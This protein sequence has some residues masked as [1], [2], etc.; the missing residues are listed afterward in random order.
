MTAVTLLISGANR[1]IGLALA[2]Q[3]AARG[4]R[5]VATAR[6]P[7]AAQRLQA[8]AALT[9]AVEIAP[10]DVLDPAS[11]EALAERLRDRPIDLVVANAG[12]LNSF[13]GL[14]SPDHDL[15]AWRTVLMTNVYGPY[16]LIRAL[17]PNL[18]R[19]AAPKAAIL[20]SLMGSSARAPGRAYPY[21]ASKA[22]ATNLARN[23]ATDLR[24]EGVAVGAYH[25]GWVRTDMGGPNAEISASESAEG[26]LKRF[27]ALSLET[28]GV[29]E[30]YQG[31]PAPF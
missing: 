14:D 25:P 6:R 2:E 9:G 19:S 21:R 29:F 17:R 5:V 28:S 24:P 12:A 27:D 13:A 4:D 3:A 11:T 30:T 10:L 20:S 15:D 31:E 1:G 7:E 16:A 22:A 23:L 18:A 26:L 8:L